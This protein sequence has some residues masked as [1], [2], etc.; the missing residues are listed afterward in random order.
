MFARRD[1]LEEAIGELE[2]GGLVGAATIV[3]SRRTWDVLSTT[4]QT[5]FRART[6]RAGVALHV[7]D[8]MSAHYVEVRGGTGD[9]RLSSEFPM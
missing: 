3:V 1:T 8:Q 4:E 7:D 2:A 5:A 9:E 6:D